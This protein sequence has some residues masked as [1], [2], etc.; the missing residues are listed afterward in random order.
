MFKKIINYLYNKGCH[1]GKNVY[2]TSMPSK[3]NKKPFFTNLLI[4][5]KTITKDPKD[6]HSTWVELDLYNINK[7]TKGAKKQWVK[8]II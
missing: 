6:P 2:S 3:K 8:L 5:K 1:T 7:K 4:T